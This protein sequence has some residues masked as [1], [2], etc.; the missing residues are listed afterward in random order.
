MKRQLLFLTI[1]LQ[2]TIAFGQS[3]EQKKTEK[4]INKKDIRLN[5]PTTPDGFERQADCKGRPIYRKESNDTITLMTWGGSI[6]E[7]LK[8]FKKSTQEEGFN[9]FRYPSEVQK[10]GTVIVNRLTKY[11][12]IWRNDTLYL[13]DDYNEAASKAQLK[14]ME[15]HFAKKISSEEYR[16][17]LEEFDKS[18]YPYT[19]KF[20]IIYFKGIFNDNVRYEFSEKENFRMESVSLVDRWTENGTTFFEINLDTH[21]KGRHGFSEDMKHLERNNCRKK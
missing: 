9:V 20:K 19:P 4:W 11:T 13:L 21:T 12:F 18:K 5:N 8:T 15:D 16:R 3:K 14:L 2:G 10:N 7:D 6:A 17:K 1:I